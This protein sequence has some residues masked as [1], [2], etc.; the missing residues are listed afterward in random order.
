MA[1]TIENSQTRNKTSQN[2]PDWGGNPTDFRLRDD[3]PN[4]TQTDAGKTIVKNKRFLEGAS[5]AGMGL[6]GGI[7]TA[8]LTGLGL[9]EFT[10]LSD[11]ASIGIGSGIAAAG[12]ALGGLGGAVLG[13]K[14]AKIDLAEA[15][16]GIPNRPQVINRSNPSN[17]LINAYLLSELL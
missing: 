7:G 14:K 12:A 15:E 16:L 5:G 9:S 3:I 6:L 17:G 1:G 2:T 11:A 13:H 4:A 8:A 10:D